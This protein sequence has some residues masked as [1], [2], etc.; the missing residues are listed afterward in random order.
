MSELDSY[1]PANSTL[2]DQEKT[3]ALAA[4]REFGITVEGLW[5]NYDGLTPIAQALLGLPLTPAHFTILHDLFLNNL[6]YASTFAPHVVAAQDLVRHLPESLFFDILLELQ[7]RGKH[8]L[9]SFLLS[10]ANLS[11]EQLEEFWEFADPQRYVPIDWQFHLTTG[12]REKV[13]CDSSEYYFQQAL[14]TGGYMVLRSETG[15]SLFIKFYGKLAAVLHEGVVTPKGVYYDN[16]LFIPVG[17]TRENILASF[18]RGEYVLELDQFFRDVN[19]V[20]FDQFEFMRMAN[21]SPGKFDARFRINQIIEDP[22]ANKDHYAASRK[23][24]VM[25]R[26]TGGPLNPIDPLTYVTN[27]LHDLDE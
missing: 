23:L 17:E 19:G 25:P 2:T 15:V 7:T 13:L 1:F 24:Y 22:Y 26:S 8:I 10:V 20:R 12:E 14:E 27:N 3:A 16:A 4:V 21:V 6:K 11:Q 9:V 5:R 18:L